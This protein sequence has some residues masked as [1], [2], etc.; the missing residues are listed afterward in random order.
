MT[1]LTPDGSEHEVITAL[2]HD[3]LDLSA[4]QRFPATADVPIA[5]AVRTRQ[6]IWLE[7]AAARA[8][9]VK[10]FAPVS[11]K[12]FC[13]VSVFRSASIEGRARRASAH[14]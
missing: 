9:A 4:W 13:A 5:E 8:K 7:S 12:I 10:R 14:G 2:G 6:P 11:E 1:L 3:Q